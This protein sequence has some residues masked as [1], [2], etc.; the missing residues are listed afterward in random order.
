MFLITTIIVSLVIHNDSSILAFAQAKETEG[1]GEM[2]QMQ[3]EENSDA[4]NGF[5]P[6]NPQPNA[7]Q[8]ANTT[9][10]NLSFSSLKQ[11]GSPVLGNPSALITIVQFG[12]FQCRFCGRFAKQTEPLLNQ[13]Y[14]QTGKV[15]LVFKHFVTHGPDSVSAAIASQ[16]A[17]EQGKFWN[18]YKILYGNQGEEN[19]G[20]ANTD[21][22][23]KFASQI[24]GIDT[25]KFNSCLDSQKYKSMIENDNAFAYK[26]GFQGTPTL[27]IEKSDGSN[28]E[29]FLGA[30]PFPSLQAIIEKRISEG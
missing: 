24:N 17:N 26:S 8:P 21:N 18:F 9:I 20:W 27:I 22:L 5:T 16:C 25:K 6:A 29:V 28:P 23:K 14:I 13:T 3:H 4:S 15:N 10:R 7:S 12:D 11:A 30:Y 1:G 19:S 2:A